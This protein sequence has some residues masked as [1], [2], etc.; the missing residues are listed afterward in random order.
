MNRLSMSIALCMQIH[1]YR[2]KQ[3]CIDGDIGNSI[4]TQWKTWMAKKF[5]TEEAPALM[6]EGLAGLSS[7]EELSKIELVIQDKEIA[8]ST[9]NASDSHIVLPMYERCRGPTFMDL[10]IGPL[11]T[12]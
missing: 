11:L 10:V 1:D 2:F 6:K 4:A 12:M 3:I 7:Q 5:K 9:S 8:R